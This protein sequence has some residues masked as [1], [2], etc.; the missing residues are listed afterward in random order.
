V[1]LGTLVGGYYSAQIS[2][3]IPQNYVRNSVIVASFLITAYFFY[4]N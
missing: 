2:R 3:N 4:A 1:L